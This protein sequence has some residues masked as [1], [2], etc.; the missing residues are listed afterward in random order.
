MADKNILHITN[1]CIIIIIEI[2][3]ILIANEIV[4][5]WGDMLMDKNSQ[6]HFNQVLKVR[7]KIAWFLWIIMIFKYIYL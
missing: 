4:Y 5:T 3:I 2:K 1:T 6:Y 7:H